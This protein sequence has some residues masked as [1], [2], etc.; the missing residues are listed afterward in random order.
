MSGMEPERDRLAEARAAD[1]AGATDR[2]LSL[3]LGVLAADAQASSPL[4][5]DV[6]RW[7]GNMHLRRG[8]FELALAQYGWSLTVSRECGY[9]M[10]GAHALN[11]QAVVRQH[12]GDFEGALE[13]YR[14]AAA[15]AASTDGHRLLGMIEQN[16][17]VVMSIRGEWDAALLRYRLS[18]R[19]FEEAAD[20]QAASW[21]LNNIG[22]LYREKRQLA[23]AEA[24]IT[25]ARTMADRGGD[26]WTLAVVDLNYAELLLDLGQSGPAEALCERALS[27]AQDRDDA[28]HQ[29]KGLKCRARIFGG[30]GR[31]RDAV[32]DLERAL[33][34]ARACGDAH[35]T[36]QVL[37]DLGAARKQAGAPAQD[38][39]RS[40]EEAVERYA[41]AGSVHGSDAV[42]SQLRALEAPE[43]VAG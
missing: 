15:E 26:A 13:L 8:E 36:T 4:R 18:L 1:L 9:V 11:C 14:H 3:Y 12:Q 2:A 34:L 35:L 43:E 28:L 38:V 23:D 31:W 37:A 30:R 39:R 20:D 40:W 17:A 10:G 29:A 5:A 42:S 21:V 27:V 22:T 41:A 24:A 25:R 33:G 19:A 7:I 16:T 32:R 6:L